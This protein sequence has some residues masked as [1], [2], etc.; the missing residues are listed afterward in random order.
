MR[1]LCKRTRGPGFSLVEL[2]AL[3]GI[4]G[5]LI[6]LSIPA[7]QRARDSA[8]RV[9]CQNNLRQ[10]GL[11]AHNYHDTMG[12]L[13]PEY[14]LIDSNGKKRWRGLRWFVLL[15]PYIEQEQLWLQ[16]LRAYAIE[17]NSLRNPPHVGLSTVIPTYICPSD[18]RL[19]APLTDENGITAAYSSYIGLAGGTKRDGAMD[20]EFGIRLAQVTDGTSNTL[21]V[22]ERPP[23]DTLQAGW[24]YTMLVLK[25]W[26]DWAERGPN[27]SMPVFLPQS[28]VGECDG[29]F[30]F[31]PGQLRNPCD[32]LHFWSLHPGG[33]NFLFCDGSV[34]FLPYSAKEIMPALGT[35]AGGEV[36]VLP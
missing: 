35:R 14:A 32:R 30:F 26:P 29:P 22:G 19:T 17:S 21:L 7:I 16:T 11:A 5:L 28:S 18:G 23:P 36:V 15:L 4:I 27:G 25:S 13:P 2:L 31:G 24:W 6:S 34:H 12:S 1:P 20:V 8:A 3:I 9:G 10:I 33:A